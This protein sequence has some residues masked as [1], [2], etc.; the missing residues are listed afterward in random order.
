MKSNLIKKHNFNEYING[1]ELSL[2][3]VENEIKVLENVKEKDLF[4]LPR[5]VTAK[6]MNELIRNLNDANK[7]RNEQIIHAYNHIKEIFYLIKKLDND[8]MQ[9]DL[10][11]IGTSKKASDQ[12]TSASNE[13]REFVDTFET[14]N[15]KNKKEPM[16]IG[17]LAIVT[18]IC[19]II[20]FVIMILH[21]MMVL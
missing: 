5:T 18:I 1:V 2:N 10:V 6:E 20:N 9:A 12:A 3:N 4:V 8:Y 11:S 15:C 13:V 21:M 16:M 7:K 14:I 19:T 17:K